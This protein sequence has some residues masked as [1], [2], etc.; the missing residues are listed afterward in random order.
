MAFQPES[1]VYDAGVFQLEIATPVQGGLGGISNAPL[2]N[3]AN[4]TAYLKQRVDALETAFAGLA[5]LNSPAFTGSPTAPDAAAG[6]SS[7]KIANTKFVQNAVGGILV[8]NVAGSS[9]V[10]LT[11]TDC[12]YAIIV[13]IGALTGNINVIV[14]SGAG[15]SDEWIFFNN[16][17]G[18]YSVTVKTAAGTGVLVNQTQSYVLYCDETNVRAAGAANQSSFTTHKVVA[19][20]GQ[21]TISVPYTPGNLV[22]FKNGALLNGA[23]EDYTAVSGVD[24]GLT[25]PAVAGDEFIAHAF[26]SFTVTDALTPAGG[27]MLG[28]LSL[29]G[30]A[31]QPLHAVPLQQV[32][33]K[34]APVRRLYTAGAT[35]NKPAGIKRAF[36]Q[37]QA[38]GGGGGGASATPG[39]SASSGSG[40]GSGGYAEAMIEAADLPASVAVA[41][42]AAG[43][44]GGVGANGSAGGNAQ[45]GALVTANGGT[46]GTGSSGSTSS[47]S[48]GAGPAGAGGASGGSAATLRSTA[49]Q[50][51]LVGFVASGTGVG[52]SGGSSALGIGGHGGTEGSTGMP[53]TGNGA[54]GAGGSEGGVS[55]GSGRSGGGGAPGIVIVWEYYE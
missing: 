13:L 7:G 40:G 45:F 21:V 49:G 23:G 25:V 3:L 38:P 12:G 30:N 39:G 16:T 22:L 10:T 48:R 15:K 42:A 11:A 19:T 5:P 28:P 26:S 6:D 17:T 41:V 53:G 43:V 31:A 2:L 33:Y 4:R 44:G 29:A 36:V 18:L 27:T 50:S 24:I 54:G 37:V 20:A 34:L 55:A 1:P 46:G 52:G 32:Q 47:I 9:N 8:K 14:P 51:G 35:W